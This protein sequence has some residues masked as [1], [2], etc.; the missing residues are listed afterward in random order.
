MISLGDLWQGSQEEVLSLWQH[1]LS[2]RAYLIQ[3]PVNTCQWPGSWS[4]RLCYKSPPRLSR[5]LLWRHEP[6]A[7]RISSGCWLQCSHFGSSRSPGSQSDWG[8]IVGRAQAREQL[9]NV[10]FDVTSKRI[11][12]RIVNNENN[13]YCKTQAFTSSRKRCSRALYSGELLL[14]RSSEKIMLVTLRLKKTISARPGFTGMA[15]LAWS[16][17][18]PTPIGNPVLP[19]SV[20]L[21]KP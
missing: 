10:Q 18:W 9:K 4:G 14:K 11:L 1:W 20:W 7:S 8:W 5:Q 3:H 19:S 6:Q 17:P 15:I 13:K 21:I 2:V 12:H 16:V